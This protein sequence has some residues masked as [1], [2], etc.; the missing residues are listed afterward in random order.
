MN[1]QAGIRTGTRT[2]T[3]TIERACEEGVAFRVIAALQVPDHTIIARFRQ[4]H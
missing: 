3:S 2:P 1:T 4:G